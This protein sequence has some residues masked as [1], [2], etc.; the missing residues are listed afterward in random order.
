MGLPGEVLVYNAPGTLV[1]AHHQQKSW[2]ST[3]LE[4]SG[5]GAHARSGR[6]C[7]PPRGWSRQTLASA[8]SQLYHA[9]VV[10][11][12]VVTAVA[13]VVVLVVEVVV[14]VEVAL[15]LAP[16]RMEPQ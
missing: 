6:P 10:V 12:G 7:C 11:V 5:G 9:V 3:A 13:V 4:H 14:V 8:S 2:S 1:S 15:P 16:L